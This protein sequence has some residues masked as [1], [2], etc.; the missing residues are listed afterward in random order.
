V[1]PRLHEPARFIKCRRVYAICAGPG[2]GILLGS[3]AFH[4]N[5]PILI[6]PD[7]TTI[8]DAIAS[9]IVVMAYVAI[10]VERMIVGMELLP[11]T[12]EIAAVAAGIF[13]PQGELFCALRS[14]DFEAEFE[15]RLLKR[16]RAVRRFSK[17][18][19]GFCAHDFGNKEDV[20]PRAD[21]AS[22]HYLFCQQQRFVFDGGSGVREARKFHVEM[23]TVGYPWKIFGEYHVGA[24]FFCRI[25]FRML[26]AF[27]IFKTGAKLA[28]L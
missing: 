11:I 19:G 20:V 12:V 3:T 5:P 16:A 22:G 17:D 7:P 21:Q 10:F 28:S 1:P 23:E 24:V 9:K 4:H 2:V 18:A 15:S 27:E 13:L 14:N 25:P 6:S 26:F 8:L